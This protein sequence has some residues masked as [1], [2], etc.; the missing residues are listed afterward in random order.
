MTRTDKIEDVI[1]IERKHSPRLA[2]ARVPTATTTLQVKACAAC[3]VYSNTSNPKR[4]GKGSDQKERRNG[5][6]NDEN[7]PPEFSLNRKPPD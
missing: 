6:E 1:E 3:T 5:R 2:F 4:D 7:K